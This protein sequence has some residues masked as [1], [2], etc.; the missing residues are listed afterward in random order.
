MNF[1][2]KNIL[3][4]LRKKYKILL[5]IFL[6]FYLIQHTL[7]K[8]F[9][10][11]L[12]NFLILHYTSKQTHFFRSRQK[13]RTT[14]QHSDR[15][16]SQ[17]FNYCASQKRHNDSVWDPPLRAIIHSS[18]WNPFNGSHLIHTEDLYAVTWKQKMISFFFFFH[19]SD[20]FN[21]NIFLYYLRC[22]K[23]KLFVK[24]TTNKLYWKEYSK[25]LWRMYF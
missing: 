21:Y 1:E 4:G 25:Y 19:I 14:A 8:L 2:I 10:F 12:Q 5:F 9:L 13:M 23:N 11:F 3:V 24:R 20:R 15:R 6:P 16:K 22:I 7:K 18:H 17:I